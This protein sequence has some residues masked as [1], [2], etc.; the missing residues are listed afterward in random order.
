MGKIRVLIIDDSAVARMLFTELISKDP[1]I[2]VVGAAQD[3]II[4]RQK[5][6]RLRPDVITLDVE[7][8]RMDGLTFLE[9]LMGTSPMPV[10]MVSSLTE[11]GGETTLRALE[12]GAVDF[13]A[14]PRIDIVSEL[15]NIVEDI[16]EKIKT[17]AKASIRRRSSVKPTPARVAPEAV[18]KGAV[19]RAMIK[20]TEKVVVI[21]ASTGGTEALKD[22]LVQLPADAPGIVIVQHMPEKFTRL[23]ADRIDK[24][25]SIDVSEARDGDK[26]IP[27]HALIAPGSHHMLLKRSGA[28]YYVEVKEGPRVNRHRP[29]VDVLFRSAA[30]YAGKNAIGVILTGMGSD[31]ANGL[32]EMRDAGGYTI[33][34]DEKT[35]V[36]FGMPKEAIETGGVNEIIPLPDISSAIISHIKA[37]YAG[38]KRSSNTRQSTV[39]TRISEDS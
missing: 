22:I 38:N 10:V 8:P 12:L 25:C 30:N 33:A 35:C 4:A 7:M 37:D 9:E 16:T 20:T 31:G 36:V 3:P 21:G 1:G 28:N 34:Q 19:P 32:K 15:P 18:I 2:E 39:P 6:K 5:I 29:S 17:A 14:K 24:L 27:G 11:K 26:V 23:F 13:V